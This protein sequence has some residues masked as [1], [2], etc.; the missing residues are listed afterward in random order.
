MGTSGG[1]SSG[2]HVAWKKK[3]A[4]FFTI[5]IIP[6]LRCHVS[7]RV[8]NDTRGYLSHVPQEKSPQKKKEKKKGKNKKFLP[9]AG[10][11]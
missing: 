3:N 2:R 5:T 9:I 7:I 8:T 4:H 11:I 1:Q 6:G 10:G